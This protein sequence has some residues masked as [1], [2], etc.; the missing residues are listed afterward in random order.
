[1]QVMVRILLMRPV[2][3]VEFTA[4]DAGGT[5]EGWG[6]INNASSSVTLTSKIIQ[7]WALERALICLYFLKNKKSPK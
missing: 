4:A 2:R 7:T 6:D 1:M 5:G 3:G